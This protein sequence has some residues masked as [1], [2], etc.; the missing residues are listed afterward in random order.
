[1]SSSI[2]GIIAFFTVLLLMPLG[3][4]MVVILEHN[5]S[6]AL[7]AWTAFALGLIG[8]F[9]AA[10]VQRKT[11][12]ATVAVLTG[13]AAGILV[14]GGW[15]QFVF[16]EFSRSIGVE[17][18]MEGSEI[19]TRPEYRVMPTSLP[20]LGLCWIMYIYGA[21]TLWTPVR[22]LRNRLGVRTIDN[23]SAPA[24]W[25]L[26]EMVLLIWTDYIVLLLLFDKSLAGP[27][28]CATITVAGLCLC[29]GILLFIKQ[30][31]T[32][33]MA[34]ALRYSIPT[35]CFLWTFVEVLIKL[36]FFTEFWIMPKQHITEMVA[37]IIAL[38][39]LSVIVLKRKQ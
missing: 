9:A 18:L 13:I 19:Y 12:S 14:W 38:S 1:M 15:V 30:L 20:F 27:S 2:R 7:L 26:V 28:H 32:P 8:I 10:Y 23:S 33:D 31:H 37:I 36:R 24:I 25:S 34:T 6:G 29:V 21:P 11:K 16:V 3:H 17:P 5:M 4:A 39:A 22:W 35:V